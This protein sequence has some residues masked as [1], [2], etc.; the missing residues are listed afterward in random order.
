MNRF[1]NLNSVAHQKIAKVTSGLMTSFMNYQ[2]VIVGTYPIDIQVEGSDIDVVMTCQDYD[3]VLPLLKKAFYHLE[4]F[5]LSVKD[6]VVC[7]FSYEG[8]YFELY[9]SHEPVEELNSYRHLMIEKTILEHFGEDFKNEVINLKR[10]GIKTEP[11]FALLL[12][13]SGNPYDAL[14]GIKNMADLSWENDLRLLPEY[15]KMTFKY[16]DKGWSQ[17]LKFI[18]ESDS[19]YLVRLTYSEKSMS[20]DLLEQL[21]EKLLVSKPVAYIEGRYFIEV[22]E[23]LEGKDIEYEIDRLPSQKQYTLGL[24]AG[25]VLKAIHDIE[26]PEMDWYEKY[27][28]KIERVIDKYRHCHVQMEKDEQ[29]IQYLR[30][31]TILLKGRPITFQHGDYHI[32][33]MILTPDDRLGVIDFNRSSFGDPWEEFDRLT[34]TWQRSP[35]FTIGQLHGYFDDVSDIFFRIMALYHAL[36]AISGIQWAIPYGEADVEVMKENYRLTMDHYDDFTTFIPKW[37]RENIKEVSQ[38]RL[39]GSI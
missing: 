13:L 32:G 19:K 29:L 17:D 10:K 38:W 16:L 33:N 21:S 5:E 14:L 39:K 2:P 12:G 37:Y 7:R 20:Y 34:F 4:G 36:N 23:W 18:A 15:D 6:V 28:M 35:F 31:N 26:G 30:D 22:Y 3:E 25:K 1:L 11:A 8:Y 27:S 9:I 24:E